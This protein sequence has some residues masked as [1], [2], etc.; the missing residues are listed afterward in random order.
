MFLRL[1][2]FV[3]FLLLAN[4]P[5]AQTSYT[6][7]SPSGALRLSVETRPDLSW[8]LYLRDQAVTK[9]APLSMDFAGMGRAG[10]R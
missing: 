2:S 10:N 9:P 1:I 4:H 8:R 3:F 5:F 7:S 6:V